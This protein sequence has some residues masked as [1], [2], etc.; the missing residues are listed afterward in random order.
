MKLIA[1]Y[2]DIGEANQHSLLL[3]QSGVL[4]HVS[5]S[6]SYMLSQIKTGALRVGLWAVLDEQ[7]TDAKSLL[8][9]PNHI[10][11]T[12]LTEEQML[13]LERAARQS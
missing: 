5:S 12:A 2:D 6:N 10:V 1:L 7:I 13:D 3:R 8:E 9:N 11:K 4:T